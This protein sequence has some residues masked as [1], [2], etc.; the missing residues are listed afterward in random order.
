VQQ[1]ALA[2]PGRARASGG[3]SRLGRALPDGRPVGIFIKRARMVSTPYPCVAPWGSNGLRTPRQR[4]G[5]REGGR[6]EPAQRDR[7]SHAARAR[8]SSGL[9]SAR[10]R[11]ASPRRAEREGG[12]WVGQDKRGGRASW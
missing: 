4:A 10:F 12:E 5:A 6:R 2:A 1:A 11:R 7:P 3:N 8:V 9:R